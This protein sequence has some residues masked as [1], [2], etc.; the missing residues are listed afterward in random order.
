MP[1][2]PQLRRASRP[3][4]ALVMRPRARTAQ[5]GL[6]FRAMR[7]LSSARITW[8]LARGSSPM[9]SASRCRTE[10]TAAPQPRP[11]GAIGGVL[12]ALRRDL[13]SGHN[14]SLDETAPNVLRPRK[15]P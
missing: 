10:V 2:R 11:A 4:R 7:V 1:G 9:A 15:R 6:L 12:R 13:C 5:A 3:L 8:A 14:F